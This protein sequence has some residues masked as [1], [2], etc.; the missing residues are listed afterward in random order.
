MAALTSRALQGRFSFMDRP[1][2]ES[3]LRWRVLL[4]RTTL[5]AGS[6]LWP[7]AVPNPEKLPSKKN[8]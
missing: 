2:P 1:T 4:V 6:R 3:L 7:R 8:F 5:F